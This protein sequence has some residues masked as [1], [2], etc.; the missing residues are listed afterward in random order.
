MKEGKRLGRERR[1][2]EVRKKEG[3]KFNKK[4]KKGKR[5][6]ERAETK[7]KNKDKDKKC[8]R[9]ILNS[10]D[11]NNIKKHSIGQIRALCHTEPHAATFVVVVVCYAKAHTISADDVE[12]LHHN[13]VS[14]LDSVLCNF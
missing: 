9:Y 5:K 4:R 13:G 8:F 11:V 14:R 1:K 2:D 6:E 7:D 12:F 3:R 10:F